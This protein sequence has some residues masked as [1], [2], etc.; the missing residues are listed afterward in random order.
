MD[1][2]GADPPRI[3]PRFAQRP[4]LQER[5]IANLTEAGTKVTQEL[6]MA[7]QQTTPYAGDQDRPVNYVDR[8]EAGRREISLV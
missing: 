8:V 5:Y 3:V 6:H 4:A 7:R 2:G 1:G